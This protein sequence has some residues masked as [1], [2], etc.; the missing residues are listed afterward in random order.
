MIWLLP[1]PIPSP[2]SKL[3]RRHQKR[4]KERKL[5]DGR[6]GRGWER[7]QILGVD[8]HAGRLRKRDNL[9]KGGEGGGVRGAKSDDGEKAKSSIG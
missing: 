4:L 6:G 2:V 8:T 9:L 1:L 5:A 3:G 7:S